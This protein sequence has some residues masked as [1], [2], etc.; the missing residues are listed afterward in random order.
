[1]AELLLYGDVG[2]D[3]TVSTVASWLK[4]HPKGAIK[5]RLNSGGGNAFEGLAIYNLLRS[6]GRRVEM[7][8]DG[9]AASA[10]S[11]IFMAGDVRK[12]AR[13]A[14]V[15][16]H[17]SHGGTHGGASE[18]R[19]HADVLSK[20]DEAMA[21][22]YAART[23][24]P[25]LEIAAL[26]EAETW[27]T[28]DDALLAGLATEI[29]EGAKVAASA[30]AAA[31]ASWRNTPAEVKANLQP[32]IE[33][34]I[35]GEV[36]YMTPEQLQAAITAALAPVVERLAAL[37]APKAEAS[38][39]EEPVIEVVE[40]K[41]EAELAQAKALFDGAVSASFKR[42]VAEG[43]IAPGAEAQF[44]RACKTPED[45]AETCAH[46]DAAAPI[47]ATSP[48]SIKAPESKDGVKSFSP[49][50][51]SFIRKNFDVS[52]W[53]TKVQLTDQGK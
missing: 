11:V 37:E 45:F 18:M 35:V 20:V 36:G 44:R 28:A 51:S 31:V 14:F 43:R 21:G 42:Y 48:V 53:T 29:V 34:A 7:T 9:L 47:V 52:K 6:T 8:V 3:I 4:Q 26:M 1:M 15:M 50:A 39:E 23:G 10:A 12:V 27:F 5:A 22:V 40:A 49:A 33:S 19:E 46:Y 24:K 25:Q 32:A 16:I 30:S 41:S 13:G 38:K 17:N 2:L